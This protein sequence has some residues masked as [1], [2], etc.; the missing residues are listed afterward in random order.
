MRT[1]SRMIIVAGCLG[2]TVRSIRRCRSPALA[3]LHRAVVVASG[4][5]MGRAIAVGASED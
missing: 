2:G 1:M 5:D 4:D 3:H